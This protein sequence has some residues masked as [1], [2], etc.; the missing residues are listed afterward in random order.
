MK[1]RQLIGGRTWEGNES[2]AR[3]SSYEGLDESTV[4]CVCGL[5]FLVAKL[6]PAC[7]NCPRCGGPAPQLCEAVECPERHIPLVPRNGKH[8]RFHGKRCIEKQRYYGERLQAEKTVYAPP[9]YRWPEVGE[10]VRARRR[11]GKPRRRGSPILVYSGD[12]FRPSGPV[13]IFRSL[14]EF[15]Q[16]RGGGV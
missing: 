12:P 5:E 4:A 16:A 13:R 1:A 3:F 15:N 10:R 11:R 6:E 8:K 2:L 7:S 9:T 14:A